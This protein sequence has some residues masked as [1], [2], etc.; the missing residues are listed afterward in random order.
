VEL[1]AENERLTRS[2][3]VQRQE[4]SATRTELE[5]CREETELEQSESSRKE[6]ALQELRSQLNE[7]KEQQQ[8]RGAEAKVEN[9]ALTRKVQKQQAQ[10][11]EASELL[12]VQQGYLTQAERGVEVQAQQAAQLQ[13]AL[14]LERRAAEEAARATA[15]DHEAALSRMSQKIRTLMAEIEQ[16][17][18]QHAQRERAMQEQLDVQQRRLSMLQPP[19]PKFENGVPV[20]SWP[21]VSV[22]CEDPC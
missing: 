11:V 7:L 8:Q 2:G 17:S 18:F 5:R 14:E 16:S 3:S 22:F 21:T 10:L 9:G 12:S 1:V 13:H 15:A 6:L 20:V 4:L 19:S